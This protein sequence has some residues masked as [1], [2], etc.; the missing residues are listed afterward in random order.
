MSTEQ[1]KKNNSKIMLISST[2]ILILVFIV[3]V[4]KL[5]SKSPS[6][7]SQPSK[8]SQISQSKYI[9]EKINTPIS[10]DTS[11]KNA[12]TCGSLA[13]T[14]EYV[15][16]SN[17]EGLY[18]INKD[19]S[20]KVELETGEISNINIYDNYLYYTKRISDDKIIRNTNYTHNII[21]QSFDGSEKTEIASVECQ[22][23]GSMLVANDLI[24][25][26]L[27]IFKGNGGRNDL[28][29]ETGELI[30]KYRA[31]ST[32]DYEDTGDV[33]EAQYNSIMT[34]N[35]PFNQSE[36]SQYL[37]ADYENFTIRNSKYTIDDTMYFEARHMK[38]PRDAAIF[39]ISKKDN[40]LNLIT[41]YDVV[42]GSNYTIESSLEGFSYNESDNSLY[43]IL[44]ARKKYS[45]R[46]SIGEKLELCKLDLNDNSITVIDTILESQDF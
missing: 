24:I 15:F 7:P 44:S 18:K 16:Y 43:Y 4:S 19:G 22:R 10:L 30:N 35:Y 23:I 21:K 45:D 33:S 6:D 2:V 28:G 40:K 27:I 26:K 17:T 36:L 8:N 9:K 20:N 3:L 41:R 5:G 46:D 42:T 34:L 14:D 29:E 39:S 12:I 32:V 13:V 11:I 25:Y 38:N 1:N 31:I 37:R